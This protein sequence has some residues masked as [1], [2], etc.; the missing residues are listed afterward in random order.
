MY[1]YHIG[2]PVDDPV[3]CRFPKRILNR[4]LEFF[5]W[6]S[7]SLVFFRRKTKYSVDPNDQYS[8]P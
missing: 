2:F 7:E 4:L 1:N 5:N 8:L 3:L 6:L